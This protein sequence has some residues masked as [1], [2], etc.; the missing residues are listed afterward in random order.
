MVQIANQIIPFVVVTFM[1]S[2][3]R[4]YKIEDPFFRKRLSFPPPL[5][6]RQF[7]IQ[8]SSAARVQRR[9]G[10]QL[11]LSAVLQKEG[12]NEAGGANLSEF[13]SL[14]PLNKTSNQQ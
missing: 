7:A 1:R 14:S 4:R 10:S 11:S 6:T 3:L 2:I 12:G 13:V 9:R 8:T 5:I